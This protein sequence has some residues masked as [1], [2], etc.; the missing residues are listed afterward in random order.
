[1]IGKKLCLSVE[2]AKA[3]NTAHTDAS[4]GHAL[5]GYTKSRNSYASYNNKIFAYFP[6]VGRGA[7]PI[8]HSGDPA[9]LPI[10]D[11]E[12]AFLP[13]SGRSIASRRNGSY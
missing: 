9:S 11:R 2:C 3:H 13:P 1:M 10:I 7:E 12:G 8:Y 6:E 4:S 5:W